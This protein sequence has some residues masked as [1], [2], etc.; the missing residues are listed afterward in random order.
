MG[1]IGKLEASSSKAD[2]W[3]SPSQ[4]PTPLKADWVGKEKDFHFKALTTISFQI[5]CFPFPF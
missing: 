5:Q 4:S 2:W 3:V 1:G